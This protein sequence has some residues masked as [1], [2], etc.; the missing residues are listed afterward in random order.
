MKL[1]PIKIDVLNTIADLEEED[2][3]KGE[4]VDPTCARD[5]TY[6]LNKAYSKEHILATMHELEV[7]GLLRLAI[8]EV[9]EQ[10]KEEGPLFFMTPLG[11]SYCE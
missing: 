3:E 1:E 4:N 2:A 11:Q 8:E 6:K 7:L 10:Y 5:I 9:Q